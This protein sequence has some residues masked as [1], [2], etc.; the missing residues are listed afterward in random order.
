MK[1]STNQLKQWFKKYA[2]PTESQFWDWLDSFWHKDELIPASQIDGLN[3]V[4]A[5]ATNGFNDALADKQDKTDNNLQTDDKTVVGAI[6]ELMNS[7]SGN[8]G[9][10]D[11]GDVGGIPDAEGNNLLDNLETGRIYKFTVS[12]ML[13]G[14]V[15][16]GTGTFFLLQVKDTVGY[17]TLWQYLV[18]RNGIDI[19]YKIGDEWE[20][21]SDLISIGDIQ[22]LKEKISKLIPKSDFSDKNNNYGKVLTHL[23]QGT[24][25]VNQV[26]IAA[27]YLYYDGTGNKQQETRSNML[28]LPAANNNGAGVMSSAD[29]Q[30]VRGITLQETVA[31]IQTA[32][33]LGITLNASNQ[34]IDSTLFNKILRYD[35]KI[36]SKENS[37]VNTQFSLYLKIESNGNLY[38]QTIVANNQTLRAVVYSPYLQPENYSLSRNTATNHLCLTLFNVTSPYYYLSG[39]KTININVWKDG[40]IDTV[41]RPIALLI[42]GSYA[43]IATQLFA[44]ANTNTTNNLQQQVDKVNRFY[45]DVSIGIDTTTPFFVSFS[46]INEVYK[47]DVHNA[48]N[49]SYFTI[50][51]RYNSPDMYCI[52]VES[53]LYLWKAQDST[54]FKIGGKYEITY[55]GNVAET[56]VRLTPYYL[57]NTEWNDDNDSSYFMLGFKVEA[58]DQD[59]CDTMLNG[60]NMEFKISTNDNLTLDGNLIQN[61]DEEHQWSDINSN[62]YTAIEILAA[63]VFVDGVLRV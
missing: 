16:M 50:S 34:V 22:D 51:S 42:G 59:W 4:V 11:L 17:T 31:Q 62:G 8:G 61:G 6:N 27:S 43:Q 18:T 14:Q 56:K 25:Q 35:F 39:T 24:T 26:D 1:Q 60:D 30:T 3:Q 52:T 55:S 19:R 29:A 2:Y 44:P 40:V 23:S 12:S 48:V 41:N 9:I 28:T 57:V 38:T 63:K 37:N 36:Q 7:L 54:E 10:I 33:D 58:L 21:W 46:I 13:I 15:V 53:N 32:I 47:G 45:T 20:E 49:K 5:G